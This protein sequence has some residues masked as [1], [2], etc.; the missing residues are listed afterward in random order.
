VICLISALNSALPTFWTPRRHD[1]GI[2]PA[3]SDAIVSPGITFRFEPS[4]QWRAL[5]GITLVTPQNAPAG[6]LGTGAAY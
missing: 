3:G 2:A 4:T 5:L 6:A 1:V